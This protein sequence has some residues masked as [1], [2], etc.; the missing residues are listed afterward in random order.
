MGLTAFSK[1]FKHFFTRPKNMFT[2]LDSFISR[3]IWQGR[4]P[5]VRYKTRQ[6]LK[7]HGGSGLPHLRH[8]W[9]ACQLRALY[10]PTPLSNDP[11]T[12]NKALEETMGRWF[13]TT[14]AA[15][16]EVQ[17]TFGLPGDVSI[18]RC[19]SSKRF[20]TPKIGRRIQKM[21]TSKS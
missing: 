4:R 13:K 18:F 5:R 2:I 9:L 6:L 8:Y 19:C 3:F 11:F 10:T 21:E 7:L 16:R 15:W 14:L 20:Y 12:E 1:H 17:R